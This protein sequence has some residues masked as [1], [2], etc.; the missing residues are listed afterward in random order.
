MPAAL[1]SDL[2]CMIQRYGGSAPSL[3]EAAAMDAEEKA[4]R[5]R[6]RAAKQKKDK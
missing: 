3:E 5:A 1:R 2:V 6:R 4:Q